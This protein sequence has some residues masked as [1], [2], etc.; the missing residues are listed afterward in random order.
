MHVYEGSPARA[1]ISLLPYYPWLLWQFTPVPRGFWYS[2]LNQR[3]AAQD[4][5]QLLQID[6]NNNDDSWQQWYHVTAQAIAEL[7]LFY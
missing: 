4:L 6:I 3:Q 5:A 2:K 1:L 7:G